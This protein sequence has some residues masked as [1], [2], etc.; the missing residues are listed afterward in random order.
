MQLGLLGLIIGARADIKWYRLLAGG[1]VI[2][3]VSLSTLHATVAWTI[4]RARALCLVNMSA[5]LALAVAPAVLAWLPTHEEAY[6][7]H[8]AIMI[9]VAV[10]KQVGLGGLPQWDGMALPQL[11]CANTVGFRNS[12]L[13]F[14]SVPATACCTF[15]HA[16]GAQGGSMHWSY[17]TT[18]ASV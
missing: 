10:G 12:L 4:P 15:M 3:R 18:L 17:S 1:Y 7:S 5:G 13:E 16:Y 14:T 6:R 8:V 9:V 11:H 2:T